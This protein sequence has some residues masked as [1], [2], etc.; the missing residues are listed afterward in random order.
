MPREELKVTL[1]DLRM[2]LEKAHFE[3]EQH[4]DKANQ[5]LAEL[6]EKLLEES[7]MSGDEYLVHELKELLDDF[8][9][10]HPRITTL[11]SRVS[12]LL[13]KIGI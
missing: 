6:E 10:E 3:H 1:Q 7:L 11:V 5:H 13:A 8:E 9:E 12:D 2:E 4:R